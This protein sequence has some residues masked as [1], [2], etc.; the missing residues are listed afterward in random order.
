MAVVRSLRRCGAPSRPAQARHSHLRGADRLDDACGR[1]S[2]TRDGGGR[3]AATVSQ[4]M[5][6]GLHGRPL[7]APCPTYQ[8]RP[9]PRDRRGEPPWGGGLDVRPPV[10]PAPLGAGQTG[11]LFRTMVCR[12]TTLNQDNDA[13]QMYTTDADATSAPRGV[14][15]LPVRLL[16]NRTEHSP[17]LPAQLSERPGDHTNELGHGQLLRH[18][19]SVTS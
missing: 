11:G 4:T 19:V 10:C 17:L 15:C 6:K 14:R 7:G 5:C 8:G 3:D 18:F 2:R 16:E 13:E 12:T 9:H 1:L